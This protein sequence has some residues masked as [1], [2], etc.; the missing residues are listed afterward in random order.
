MLELRF[1]PVVDTP[2]RITAFRIDGSEVSH[3]LGPA[4]A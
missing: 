1:P 2:R 3:S 4:S